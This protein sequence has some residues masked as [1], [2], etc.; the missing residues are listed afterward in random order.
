MWTRKPWKPLSVPTPLGK[1]LTIVCVIAE[2]GVGERTEAGAAGGR[3][4]W[5]TFS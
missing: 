2:V 5:M 1:P 3:G 4:G